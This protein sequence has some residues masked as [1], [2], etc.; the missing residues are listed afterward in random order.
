[1]K[2]KGFTL[3]EIIGVVVVLG[4][5][6][7]ITVPTVNVI[8]KN[9]K[10]K[11]LEATIRNLEEAA[12]NYSN[13]YDIGHDTTTKLLQ[14]SELKQKGYIKNE[15]I[16]NPVTNSEMNGCIFYKWDENN[17]QYIF[18]YNEECVIKDLEVNI[19]NL[20]GNF[21][22]RGWANKDFYVNINT[23][24]DSYKYCI[25]DDKC[26]P[27]VLIN[28]DSG[29]ALITIES[30]NI[31]VCVIAIRGFDNSDVICSDAYKLDKTAPEP[32]SINITGTKSDNDWY[33]SNVEI[34]VVEGTDSLS[35][36]LSTTTN[37]TS[38][39][40]NTNGTTVIVTTKDN[41]D[42]VSTR[43]YTIKVDKIEPDVEIKKEVVDNKNVLTAKV[44]SNISGYTYEW[45]KDGNKINGATSS[46]YETQEA[47]TYKVV[48]TTGA[49]K[50]ITSNEITIKSYTV[51]Y[52]LNGATGSITSTNK[53]QDINTNITNTIPTRTG[54]D[55]LGWG[56]SSTDT[57]VDYERNSVYTLN[58]NKTLYAIWKKTVTITFNGNGAN[59]ASASVS[60]DMYNADASCS[61]TSPVITREGYTIIGYNTDSTATTSQWNSNSSKNVSENA[62][63]NAITSKEIT[64]TFYRNNAAS[65]TPKNGSASTATSLTQKCIMWN[66]S[67]NC[68]ITSPTIT[69]PSN[70]P[71]VVGW[72]ST[73]A[74]TSNEWSENTAKTFNAN[75]SYYAVT[76]KAKTILTAKF[77]ANG[78]NLS[79]TSDLACDIAAT[80]NGTA[81]GTSCTVTAPTITRTGYVAVG[82]NTSSTATTNNSSYDTSTRILTLTTSNNNSTWYAITKEVTLTLNPT[83]GTGYVGGS[84]LTSTVGGSNYGTLSCTSGNNSIA[85]C[86]T[87]GT[88]LI[89]KPGNTIG[90][91]IITLKESNANKTATYTVNVTA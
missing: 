29:A 81:Q 9:G 17:K 28:K 90:E 14:I 12:Y 6:A 18:S 55:F 11:A 68:S 62:T 86:S 49:G 5:L 20:D 67:V 59:V 76:T 69:A 34:E 43:E 61:I 10:Q 46:S 32:G 72:D 78:A 47:G 85:T 41:A 35:G 40:E 66:T 22:D 24:G 8:I 57:T 37:I 87:S 77:N 4:V 79:S 63:Y 83:S 16:I 53:V 36:H 2:K 45:Y 7:L 19:T 80:Y 30:D 21:N 84:N 64:V 56:T 70:T 58:E 89:I 54:Y 1:M 15:A 91:T 42:N 65:I 50:T 60:C 44:N 51:S 75:A 52:N 73:S 74:Y 71:T 48:V 23:T 3:I 26:E 39:T 31:N 25:S 88:T 27:T 13:R 33:T 82:Y 38:I